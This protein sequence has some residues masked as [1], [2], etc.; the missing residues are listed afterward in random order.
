[1]LKSPTFS[2]FMPRSVKQYGLAQMSITA[3]D[4]A[5]TGS[6]EQFSLVRSGER[7]SSN[8]A[9]PVPYLLI[10]R[11]S[12]RASLNAVPSAIAVSCVEHILSDTPNIPL[13]KEYTYQL[14][15]GRR[16]IGLPSLSGSA[17]SQ[18]AS[19]ERCTSVHSSA[20][21]NLQRTCT[22]NMVEETDTS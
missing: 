19:P 12:P 8:G 17:T 1:M 9:K 6:S 16:S 11:T 2:R 13:H 18:N 5:Y 4:N 21:F 3:R 15:G 20:G 14:C 10:P 7:T 22:A